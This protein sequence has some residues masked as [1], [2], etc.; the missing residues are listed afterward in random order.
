MFFCFVLFYVFLQAEWLCLNCQTQRA[1]AGQLGDMGKISISDPA[2]KDKPTV[3][4][5]TQ[6]SKTPAPTQA[7]T[8]KSKPKPS[9][10]K[11]AEE[12]TAS[13]TVAKSAV[14]TPAVP[15]PL[16]V[17]PTKDM[18]QTE[19][20][21]VVAPIPAAESQ[22]AVITDAEVT[23]KETGKDKVP[24]ETQVERGSMSTLPAVPIEADVVKV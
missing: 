11:Q 10:E 17:E 1:I 9:P 21:A 20:K 6:L 22:K 18:L 7:P 5:K 3:T 24:D 15:A 13:T 19:M 4:P 14:T 16:S 12:K 23:L 2:I 8:L